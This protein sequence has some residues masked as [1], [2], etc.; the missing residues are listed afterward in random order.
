VASLQQELAIEVG[1]KLQAETVVA[2]LAVK[3][4]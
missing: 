3:V 1:L 4:A 2:D